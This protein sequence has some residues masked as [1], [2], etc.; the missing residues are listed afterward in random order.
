MIN[1]ELENSC[2]DAC[3]SSL[4]ISAVVEWPIEMLEVVLGDLFK[5]L[6]AFFSFFV[7]VEEDLSSFFVILEDD[8]SCLMGGGNAATEVVAW[9][10]EEDE[11]EEGAVGG[12]SPCKKGQ[13]DPFLQPSGRAKNAQGFGPPVPLVVCKTYFPLLFFS[14]MLS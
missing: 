6:I 14:A 3:L 7:I 12:A 11:D 2:V 13:D 1:V 8:P 4:T 10:E 9:E 5:C